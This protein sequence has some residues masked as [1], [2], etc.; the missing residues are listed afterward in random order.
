MASIE[1]PEPAEGGPAVEAA[2]EPPII[3]IVGPT[4]VGKTALALELAP[5]IRGEVISADSR[6]VYRGM[7][8]GTAQPT[9][10]ELARVR[11]HL[12]GFLPPDQ[13][14]SAAQFVDA[15]EQALA[16]IARRGGVALV[17]GGTYHYVQALLDRLALPRVPP[18]WERRRALELAS[19]ERRRALHE[20]LA[21]LDPAAAAAIPPSN[22]RRVIRALEVIEATGRPFSEVGRRRGRPRRALWL[23]LT[24]PRQAL[25]ARVDARVEEMLRRG[26]LDEIRALLAAGYSPELPA[27][28]STGYR[29]LIRY[30]RGEIPL[31]EAIRLVKYSTHAYIRRQYAWL[32]RDP[33]LI[34]LE[35]GPGLVERA[36]ALVHD[37]LKTHP[38]G[39]QP[40]DAGAERTHEAS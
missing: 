36:R 39:G 11:H 34:W 33:R 19:P 18:R 14:F 20:Q 9:A 22:V 37:C 27:L 8:I 3:A 21:R 30:L 32:R 24:M 35:Q 10:E 15:A 2:A 7:A 38:P 31:D 26:W 6:Q 5:E 16:D 25:Y 12:V 4:G 13:P 1:H 40:G 28:T 23:A 17:V 29:E